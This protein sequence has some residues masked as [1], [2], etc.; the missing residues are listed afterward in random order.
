[1]CPVIVP[2]PGRWELPDMPMSGRPLIRVMRVIDADRGGPT[3]VRAG[4]WT[5]PAR[6]LHAPDL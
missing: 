5:V 6:S 2:L 4:R 1:M 3:T